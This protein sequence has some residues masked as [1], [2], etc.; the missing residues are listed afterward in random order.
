MYSFRFKTKETFGEAVDSSLRSWE[1]ALILTEKNKEFRRTML[2]VEVASR[3][4]VRF[5]KR[6]S[7]V[8][9]Q[10]YSHSHE[11]R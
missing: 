1:R 2:S 6:N 5:Q 8:H 4:E 9:F 3:L 11:Q 10:Q 7:A